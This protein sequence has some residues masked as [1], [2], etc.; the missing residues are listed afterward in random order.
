MESVSDSDIVSVGST[1]NHARKTCQACYIE[2]QFNKKAVASMECARCEICGEKVANKV[3]AVVTV[4]AKY[5]H[6]RIC[7]CLCPNCQKKLKN[8]LVAHKKVTGGFR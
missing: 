1:T 8:W 7:W 4:G 3:C 5:S 2:L 6:Q